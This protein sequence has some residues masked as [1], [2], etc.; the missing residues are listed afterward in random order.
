[1]A[2]DP[3][4]F[5]YCETPP[6]FAPG[7]S[8]FHIKGQFYIQAMRALARLDTPVEALLPD[9][10]RAFCG[11]HFLASQWYD[12]LPFP[13][14]AMIEAG[15]R[16]CDVRDLTRQQA[17]RAAEHG[18]KGVY[19]LFL[20]LVLPQDIALRGLGGR[21]VS[22]IKQFYDFGPAAVVEPTD[23]QTLTI[24]RREVPLCMIEWWSINAAGYAER[25]LVLAGLKPPA[26]EYRYAQT[27]TID[28]VPVGRV[29]IT[30]HRAR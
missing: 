9:D 25:A 26:L 8:P 17:H 20:P 11:Q 5:E 14:L 15:A 1:M 4:V 22:A 29:V 27:G 21:M 2:R 7:E 3:R 16:N 23:S 18:L 10:L 30:V 13:R 12:V 6:P 24:E 19:R 28:A